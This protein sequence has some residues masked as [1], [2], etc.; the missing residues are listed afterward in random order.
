MTSLLIVGGDRLDK[1]TEK[2]KSEGIKKIA[3]ISGR[4]VKMTEAII[5]KDTDA[6]LV[7]TDFVNHNLA[8]AIKKQAKEK[9]VPTFFSKRSWA[10]IQETLACY[11]SKLTV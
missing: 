8:K 6:V 11:S 5:S 10:S 1:I 9:S 3:H 4:K 7:I 2:L